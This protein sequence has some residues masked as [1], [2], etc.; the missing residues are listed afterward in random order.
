[1]TDRELGAHTRRPATPCG[2]PRRRA[3]SRSAGTARAPRTIWTVA[4][5]DIE[6]ADACR[7]L[8][9]RYLHVF[10]PTTAHG[11][12]PLGRDLAARGGRRLRLAR[13][14]AGAR[15]IAA[16][17]RVAARG[18]RAGDAAPPTT[19]AAAARL[20]PSGDAYFLLDRAERELL[21]PAADQR[22]RLW[23]SRVWPGA[24][25][26]DGE[27]RGTWRRAQHIVQD[28]RPGRACRATGARRD[29]GRGRRPAR[30]PAS[31]GR[32][33]W[34]GT[35]GDE[36]R[37]ARL[38]LRPIVRRSRRA[39]LGKEPIHGR[40]TGHEVRHRVDRGGRREPAGAS[41]GVF[42]AL[43]ETRPD[44]VSYLVLR[45]AD[46]IVRPRVVPRA[47]PTTR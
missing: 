24:L 31:T 19:A 12:R 27:I 17:R 45:L 1:M 46:G 25:L 35:M 28:R 22:Q 3:P 14:I 15:P 38:F 7:E 43:E 16:R 6:P 10:G 13:G 9:R 18:R 41:R 2:T 47:P 32:S 44:D 26:V 21:V 39:W 30:S 11:I 42:A 36:R 4:A 23:T 29:R 33:R 5:A 20:L 37:L 34:S 8:A 40:A